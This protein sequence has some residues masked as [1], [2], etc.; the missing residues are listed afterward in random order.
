MRNSALQLKSVPAA[1]SAPRPALAARLVWTFTMVALFSAGLAAL[2]VAWLER[3]AARKHGGRLERGV[4]EPA[5]GVS[6][7]RR[8]AVVEF[9]VGA[10]PLACTYISTRSPGGRVVCPQD[11]GAVEGDCDR[12]VRGDL[13]VT[14]RGTG[15]VCPELGPGRKGVVSA[16][17]L[18]CKYNIRR[19]R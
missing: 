15:W 16:S 2:A 7:M 11:Y 14:W 4:Y 19:S 18:C 12:A 10:A 6:S 17:V 8:E 9:E 13:L 3:A 1:G 5:S